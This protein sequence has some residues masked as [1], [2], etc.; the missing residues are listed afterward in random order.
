MIFSPENVAKIE[1]GEKTQTR[2]VRRPYAV[3]GRKDGAAYDVWDFNARRAYVP[4]YE[5][6]KSYA[7]Q[8]GRGKKAVGRIRITAIRY[9]ER[10]AE[11]SEGDA[12]A[13]GFATPDEFRAV[14]ARING[15]AA[16]DAPCWAIVF[17][18]EGAER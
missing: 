7:V 1:A 3:S 6:G 16:L 9:C 14:Y 10:A 13:E 2:R 5:V 4:I 11:I 17:E 8:P 18:W 12:V 15:T